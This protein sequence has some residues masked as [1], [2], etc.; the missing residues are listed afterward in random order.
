MFSKTYGEDDVVTNQ[1][2]DLSVFGHLVRTEEMASVVIRRYAKPNGFEKIKYLF[3]TLHMVW[4]ADDCLAKAINANE[5]IEIDIKSHDSAQIAHEKIRNYLEKTFFQLTLYHT[6]TSRASVVYQFIA[7]SILTR[8][9]PILTPD[10]YHDISLLFASHENVVSAEIPKNLQRLAKAITTA[11][12]SEQFLSQPSQDGIEFLQQ[13]SPDIY[14]EFRAFLNKHG[15]RSLK[16]FE[17][18]ANTWASDPWKLMDFVKHNVKTGNFG[19]DDT[20]TNFSVEE[21]ARNLKTPK[22][23]TTRRLLKFVMGKSRKA[24][25]RR[26]ATKCELIR[27]VDKLRKAY[28][29][30]AEKLKIA[31]RLPSVDLIFHLSD[32]EIGEVIRGTNTVVLVK[33]SLLRRRFYTK[34]DGLKFPEISRGVPVALQ[35]NNDND[36]KTII[37]KEVKGTP[38]CMGEIKGRACVIN[39]VEDANQLQQGDIL[40]T[41]CTDTAWSLYFPMLAGI[42]TEL[43]GLISHG[44]YRFF[45]LFFFHYVCFYYLILIFSGAVIAR[46]FCLPCIV[47]TGNATKIFKTGDI[48][49]L[50]GTKGVLRLIK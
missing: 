9:Q 18:Q 3:D 1:S 16:E 47:G 13:H 30:L 40:I 22:N 15:H 8:D 45:V 6:I 35:D 2:L 48:V 10:H 33:K 26:E 34:W 5:T 41:Y 23:E 25:A 4:I 27:S 19:N 29:I 17:L 11:G 46:E 49:H 36:N 32:Y 31:G 21:T 38:V 39:N 44:M 37:D 50:S 14:Q 43:G 42:V 28:T 12:L 20:Q 7:L 24:V